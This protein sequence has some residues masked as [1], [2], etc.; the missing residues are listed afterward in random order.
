MEFDSVAEAD[1][2]SKRTGVDYVIMS[3]ELPQLCEKLGKELDRCELECDQ[4]RTMV[5][6]LEEQVH[7]YE[8]K[9]RT[10]RRLV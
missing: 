10:I 2:E 3:E 1:R 9:L 6:V 4:L 5:K 8:A 7:M